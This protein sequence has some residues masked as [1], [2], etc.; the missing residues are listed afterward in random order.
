[1]T[2]R[3]LIT[4]GTGS[5]LAISLKRGPCHL[6]T[7]GETTLLFDCGEGASGAIN[8]LGIG[9]DISA[10]YITHLHV[11][12]IG[13]LINLI[14]NLVLTKRT[15]PL[16]VFMPE[17]GIEAI[18]R[19]RDATYLNPERFSFESF[20]TVFIPIEPGKVDSFGSISVT[21]WNS[22][23]FSYDRRTS[24]VIRPAFGFTIRYCDHR[25]VYTGDIGSIG[26]FSDELEPNT[27]LLC[28]GLHIDFRMVVDLLRKRQ[29]GRVVFTHFDSAFEDEF[30][31]FCTAGEDLIIAKDGMEIEW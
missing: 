9:N 18:V 26:C 13:G 28:E 6:V 8:D 22:D 27:T 5:G 12:H 1:M 7:D 2:G 29:V 15:N 24:S 25:L 10:V 31:A 20:E 11:D 30:A 3:R 21:A 16:R 4:I 23:H 17:E 14:Q 19:L